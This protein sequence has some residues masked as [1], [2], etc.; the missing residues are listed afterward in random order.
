VNGVATTWEYLDPHHVIVSDSLSLACDGEA[1]DVMQR[2]SFM[3][4]ND[5]E[6]CI[7]LPKYQAIPSH[8]HP[9]ISNNSG[10]GR[11][12]CEIRKSSLARFHSRLSSDTGKTPLHLEVY[13][14]YII[15][16]VCVACV[17]S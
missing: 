11:G 3:A 9:T 5:G 16:I 7:K 2:A 10:S 14:Y 17:L 15:Y 4:A 12:N 13:I 8:K 1:F 6:L